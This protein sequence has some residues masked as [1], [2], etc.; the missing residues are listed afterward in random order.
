MN[1]LKECYKE[2]LPIDVTTDFESF[3]VDCGDVD[4]AACSQK[5]YSF[6]KPYMVKNT[7]S[8]T[9]INVCRRMYEQFKKAKSEEDV[10]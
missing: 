9:K 8:C 7:L 1:T 5:I 6:D 10:H 2:E 3:C 4:L